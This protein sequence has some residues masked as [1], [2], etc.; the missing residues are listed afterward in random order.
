M[1]AKPLPKRRPLLP[2]MAAAV[3]A[4]LLATAALWFGAIGKV[5]T[6][7]LDAPAAPAIAGDA[8]R[9]GAAGAAPPAS[10]PVARVKQALARRAVVELTDSFERGME[11]WGG[12]PRARVSGWSRQPGGY[13]RPGNLALFRPSLDYTDYHMEFLGQI[14]TKG[15]SWV[16][17]ARDDRNYVAM[18]L[19]VVEPGAWPVISMVHYPVREGRTGAKV[20]TALPVRVCSNTAYHVDVAVKGNRFVVSLEGE[21]VDSWTDE[22]PSSGGVGFFSEASEHARLYWV[23][24]KKNDDWLG[25]LCAFIAGSGAGGSSESAWLAP[26]PWPAP[27]PRPFPPPVQAAVLNSRTAEYAGESLP[28]NQ[29]SRTWVG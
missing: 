5:A 20:E 9:S 17:R 14:E 7:S 24:V 22:A 15:M 19:H 23:K 8:A 1:R 26:A 3:A 21:E 25:R 13:V 4:S 11:S 27:A 6:G 29:R 2:G 12:E 28:P 16:M 18:K 10:G